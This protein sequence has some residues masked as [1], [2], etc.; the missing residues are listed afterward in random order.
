MSYIGCESSRTVKVGKSL[1][2]NSVWSVEHTML[3]ECVMLFVKF[4]K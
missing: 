1:L 3:A 4:A 2:R